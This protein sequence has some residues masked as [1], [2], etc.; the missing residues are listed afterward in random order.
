MGC[1]WLCNDAACDFEGTEQGKLRVYQR[2]TEPGFC[3]CIKDMDA[4][5]R[6]L[7]MLPSFQELG[8]GLYGNY[9]LQFLNN[10]FFCRCWCSCN[11][12]C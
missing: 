2:C 3:N 11:M 8:E 6:L 1:T 4:L 12:E 7:V 9:F 10:A 5:S